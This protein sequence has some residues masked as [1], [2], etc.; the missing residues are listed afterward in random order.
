MR[1]LIAGEWLDGTL[2]EDVTNP[3][4]GSVIDTVPVASSAEVERALEAAV[5]GAARQR[6]TPAYDRQMILM[7]AAD[8]ADQRV[9]DLARTISLESGKLLA[10]ATGEASRAGDMLRLAAFESAVSDRAVAL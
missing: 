6:H 5:R 4:D 2:R 8:I 7:R 1:M 10:E 9:D 3:F